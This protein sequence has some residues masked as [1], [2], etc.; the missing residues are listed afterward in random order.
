MSWW[1]RKSADARPLELGLDAQNRDAGIAYVRRFVANKP[2]DRNRLFQALAL[3]VVELD[4]RG[5]A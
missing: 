4:E 5:K 3:A 1:N 2:V